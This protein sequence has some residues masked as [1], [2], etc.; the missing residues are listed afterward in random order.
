MYIYIR[1]IYTSIYI[2]YIYIYIFIYIHIYICTKDIFVTE[3]YF[4]V[5]SFLIIVLV[6]QSAKRER[7]QTEMVRTIE[8]LFNLL[9]QRPIPG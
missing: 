4:K 2:I 5:S 7:M 9:P 6:E 8:L 3:N 1:D